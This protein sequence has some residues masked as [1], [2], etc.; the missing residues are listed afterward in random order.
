MLRLALAASVSLPSACA[1]SGSKPAET[2]QLVRVDPLPGGRVRLSFEPVSPTAALE[3]MERDE[4]QAVLTVFHAAFLSER[5]EIRVRLSQRVSLLD[6][7]TWERRLRGQFLDRFGSSLVPLPDS[8][9]HSRFFQA[10]KLSPQYMGAGIREAAQELFSSPLFV[11]SV[12]LSVLVYFAAWLAPEPL[13][14][15]AFA[16]TVTAV[17]ALTVGILEVT[18]LALACLRLYREAEAAR[19]DE[20][21]RAASE[22]F[23]KSV[24]GTALRVILRASWRPWR[25]AG[26]SSV[27]GRGRAVAGRSRHGDGGR[28][29]QPGP[30]WGNDGRSR[31]APLCG[32]RLD[33]P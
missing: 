24:G 26:A 19:S 13:F 22:R 33:S 1:T 6:E 20:A 14:S 9:E 15:K 30:G 4:A 31:H 2:T 29:R 17:L 3:V 12:S 10:L 18:N 27:C 21:L 5:P 23:G 32:H 28:G 7:G 8:L 25:A 11:A 16:A